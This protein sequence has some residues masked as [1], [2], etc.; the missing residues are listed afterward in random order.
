MSEK[1]KRRRFSMP[2]AFSILFLLI[3]AIAILTWIIPAGK[4]NID[5]AGNVISHSYHSVANKPQGLWDVL[6]APVIGMVGNAKTTGAISISLFILVIG[7]FLGVVNQTGALNDGIKVLVHK[8]SKQKKMLIP[9]LTVLFALGGSTFGMS[10]ETMAFY[11]LLIPIMQAM[12]L[13]S[14]VAVAIPLVGTQVGNL[15]STVNP[16]A[17][18]VASQTLHIS[19]GDGLI[20]R[21]VLL[22]LTLVFSIWYIYHYAAKIE[23]DPT[24]SLLYA[25]KD[26]SELQSYEEEIEDIPKLSKGQKHVLWLF[27]LTFVIMIISLVPW[28]T[29]NPNWTFFETF[30]K[31]LR[32]VPFLG[33]LIGK[34]TVAFGSWYFNEITML[35]LGMSILIKFVYHIPEQKFVD[36]F[37]GGVKDFASVAIVVA[38]ARGIQVVMDAGMITD[39]VLHWGE[40]ALQ[41]SNKIMYTLATY[42]FYLP[43]TFLIPSTSGLAAAT[44]GI[45]GPM[46]HFA[47]VDSNIVVSIYQAASGLINMLTPTS[48]VVVGA[49]QIAHINISTWWKWAWKMALGLLLISCTYLVILAVL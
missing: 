13:D 15:A 42:V 4:Y 2:S 28:Q 19:M 39:T 33:A 25:N 30:L 1:N 37:M 9:L 23:N 27:G 12:G 34:D 8:Y 46:G 18:G 31:W 7:G 47:G 26:A 41:G 40:L 44:M 45:I 21:L 35:F 5:Q 3:V 43:M 49:M 11:P 6:M 14:L 17:T 24:K 36:Y 22:A 10:E 32:N 20:S 16:F 48:A 29:I 38:L